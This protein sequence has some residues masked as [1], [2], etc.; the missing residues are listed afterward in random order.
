MYL[1]RCLYLGCSVLCKLISN[2]V[3]TEA[4]AAAAAA[5]AAAA[6]ADANDDGAR[7]RRRTDDGDDGDDAAKVTLGSE[8]CGLDVAGCGSAY[9]RVAV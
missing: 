2:G 9:E 3:F 8:H 1:Q 5:A 4:S 7:Q 6:V